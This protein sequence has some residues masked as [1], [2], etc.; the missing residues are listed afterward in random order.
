MW[1]CHLV[2]IFESVFVINTHVTHTCVH[3]PTCTPAPEFPWSYLSFFPIF[4][5]Y[6]PKQNCRHSLTGCY[7][8]QGYRKV[9]QRV[10]LRTQW[11]VPELHRGSSELSVLLPVYLSCSTWE[12][13]NKNRT[14]RDT[15]PPHRPCLRLPHGRYS[16]NIRFLPFSPTPTPIKP[17]FQMLQSQM[18]KYSELTVSV[19][20]WC[21]KLSY[22]G[23]GGLVLRAQRWILILV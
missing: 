11:R 5:I 22:G 9:L 16:V 21:V 2:G 19:C 12:L 10:C 1:V 13:L 17:V 4:D 23:S 7:A 18:S 20:I 6:S 3:R 8:C 14:P 15:S